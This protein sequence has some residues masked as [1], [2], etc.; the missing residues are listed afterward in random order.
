MSPEEW[1]ARGDAFTHDGQRIFYADSAPGDD[2]SPAVLLLH[3]FPTASWDWHPIWDRL[4]GRRLVAP[5]F[6]GFG[7]SD[8][9]A[10]RS[11]EIST[12]ADICEALVAQLGLRRYAVLAHDYGDTV[13]QE[14]LHRDNQRAPEDR[15]WR[16]VCF[17]NGGL[18]PE[19]HR[20]RLIQ[21]LLAG[22]LGPTLSRRLGKGSFDRS[23]SAVFG[24]ETKPSAADL[25]AFWALIERDGGRRLFSSGITYMAQRRRFR[26]RWVGA[27]VDAHC[28]VQLVNGSVDPVSGAHMVAR[29]REVVRADDAIVEL[30]T[31]GHYPQFEAPGPVAEAFAAF[32]EKHR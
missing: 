32:E 13:A 16:C 20:A 19:T 23:F 11:Y 24:P 29:Y 8:K 1:E 7:L 6:L 21:K 4:P 5:D 12:Q 31:I 27:L 2:T 17:L 10:W 22:P 18:F 25:A 15:Q 3:G 28:P 30:P 14:L 9:P 26:A